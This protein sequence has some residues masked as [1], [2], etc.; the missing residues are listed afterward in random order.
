MGSGR[1]AAALPL[2]S[3]AAL[4]GASGWTIRSEGGALEV[5]DL[6]LLEHRGNCF[7]ALDANLI[8]AHAAS[9]GKVQVS[10]RVQASAGYCG[11]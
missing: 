7:A 10:G 8:G 5:G 6:R 2:I 9:A 1:S 3:A 4:R 11:R